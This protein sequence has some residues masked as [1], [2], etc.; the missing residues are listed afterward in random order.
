MAGEDPLVCV[1]LQATGMGIL[2][3]CPRKKTTLKYNNKLCHMYCMDT[4]YT[5]TVAIGKCTVI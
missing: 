4:I 5:Y 3:G 1:A 2:P